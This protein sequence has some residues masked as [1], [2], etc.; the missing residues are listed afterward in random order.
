VL[1]NVQAGAQ[2]FPF[3]GSALLVGGTPADWSARRF[4]DSGGNL[5]QSD[6][7]PLTAMTNAAVTISQGLVRHIEGVV[8]AAGESYLARNNATTIA[9]GSSAR[10][11]GMTS[12]LPF[13]PPEAAWSTRPTSTRSSTGPTPTQTY[14]VG[15]PQGYTTRP[16]TATALWYNTLWV[17]TGPGTITPNNLAKSTTG[18]SVSTGN[19]CTP[20]ELQA[21]Q[22]WLYWACGT[23]SAGLVDLQQ[24]VTLSVPAGP[25]LVGDGYLGRHDLT[26]AALLL[27]D[28]HTGTVSGPT[29][30]ANN[31]PAGPVGDDR[32]IAF[33]VDRFS[34][35]IAW[36]DAADAVH[37]VDPGVPATAPALGNPDVSSFFSPATGWVGGFRSDP[38]GVL[39]DPADPPQDHRCRGLD[40]GRWHIDPRHRR[41][42]GRHDGSGGA[43][44]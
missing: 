31:V 13:R 34:G 39:V 26:S 18:A 37:V 17:V 7:V 4:T 14:V 44:V 15:G 33:A 20:T 43:R 16:T 25:V 23:T 36:V 30:V 9:S 28:F 6:V 42:L 19:S 21:T 1:A 27:Y 29:T 10:R 38:P 22:R 12:R 11:T 8:T 2:M 3:D 32:N 24:H 35:D 5:T 40:A 41:D